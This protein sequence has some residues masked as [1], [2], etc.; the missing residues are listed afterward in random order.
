MI[1]LM[2]MAIDDYTDTHLHRLVDFTPCET[3]WHLVSPAAAYDAMNVLHGRTV[4]LS[5]SQSTTGHKLGTKLA[6]R[7][8]P[9]YE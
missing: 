6:I 9:N 5:A 2:I 3:R 8:E 1:M 4:S 7:H